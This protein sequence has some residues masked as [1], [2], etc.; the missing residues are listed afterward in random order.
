M[1]QAVAATKLKLNI[2]I[3]C[4]ES[5]KK[6]FEVCIELRIHCLLVKYKAC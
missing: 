1:T 2:L 4:A 3:I 6:S 5:R